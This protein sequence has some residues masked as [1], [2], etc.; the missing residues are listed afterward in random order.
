[1]SPGKEPEVD[2]YLTRLADGRAVSTEELA[3]VVYDD[4]RRLADAFFR[5]ERAGITLQPTALVHEA[6]L[7]LVA[8]DQQSWENR[9]HF[10]AVAATAM[11]RVLVNAAKSRGREKRG[12]GWERVTLAGVES[13]GPV[14]DVGLVELE[15]A[16]QR[17]T[18]VK[19]R[20]VRIVELR[21][22]A[23]LTLDEVG[24]VL[25]VSRTI[26]VREWAKAKAWLTTW[27]EDRGSAG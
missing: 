2:S 26:I 6:Y 11:R 3:P 15:E 19:E 20:Y 25:G 9:A 10:L 13:D 27:L 7:K 24:E 23:G 16:L 1:M 4:L 18:K 14:G 5:R 8:Q 22:F 21:Y 17:L 12:R